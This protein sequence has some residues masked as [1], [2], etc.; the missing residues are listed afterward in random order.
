MGMVVFMDSIWPIWAMIAWF[1]AVLG[2][3]V[4]RINRL[5]RTIRRQREELDNARA[6]SDPTGKNDVEHG[7]VD[8]SP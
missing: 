6:I 1:A 5:R 3:Q 8:H 4:W 7:P 2:L